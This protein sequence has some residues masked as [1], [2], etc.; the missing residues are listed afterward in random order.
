MNPQSFHQIH[1]G[2]FMPFSLRAEWVV[3]VPWTMP[4]DTVCF[5]S[6]NCHQSG[7][8]YR[9]WGKD[10]WAQVRIFFC[11]FRVT[12]LILRPSL[13]QAGWLFRDCINDL[14]CLHRWDEPMGR[15]PLWVGT[16]LCTFQLVDCVD[17]L[18]VCLSIG[19]LC[20]LAEGVLF[21]WLI[22]LIAEGAQ[23]VDCVD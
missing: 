19:W 13:W 14:S 20:W 6:L 11:P 7:L 2:M 18:R 15:H 10:R 4:K 22:V 8:K 21:N 3:S 23:L 9:Y 16:W 12:F 17:W 1:K 5:L